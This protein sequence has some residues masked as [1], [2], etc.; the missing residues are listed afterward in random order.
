MEKL[1]KPKYD[2]EFFKVLDELINI[3]SNI[4]DEYNLNKNEVMR[5]AYILLGREINKHTYFFLSLYDKYK[6]NDGNIKGGCE[7][8]ELSTRKVK[9]IHNKIVSRDTTCKVT[10]HM[11]GYILNC[12]EF[13]TK[14][15]SSYEITPYKHNDKECEIHHYFLVCEGEEG[16]KYFLTLNLVYSLAN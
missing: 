6:N 9:D 13:E 15:I 12:L 11:L 1:R 14:I 3:I 2:S 8:L 5:L 16:K 7:T 10:A 4:R